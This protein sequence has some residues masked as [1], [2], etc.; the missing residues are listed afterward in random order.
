[1]SIDTILHSFNGQPDADN[2]QQPSGL[3]LDNTTVYGA[4]VVGGTS[5]LVAILHIFLFTTP[6]FILLKE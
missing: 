5:I 2:T 4:T 1:M 6:Q 3:I